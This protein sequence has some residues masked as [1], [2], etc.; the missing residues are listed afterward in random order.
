MSIRWI[1]F[2]STP[3]DSNS[4]RPARHKIKIHS[5]PIANITLRV[6]HTN[7][8]AAMPSLCIHPS[9]RGGVAFL[10]NNCIA[11]LLWAHHQGG[12]SALIHRVNSARCTPSTLD[13]SVDA[14]SFKTYWGSGVDENL[15]GAAHNIQRSSYKSSPHKAASPLTYSSEPFKNIVF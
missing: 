7:S 11:Q 14:S 1:A 9:I 3:C 13:Y 10:H 5:N 8:I 6:L 15:S 2:R 4:N 12:A